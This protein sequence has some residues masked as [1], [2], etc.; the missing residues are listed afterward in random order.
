[1]S[2]QNDIEH[3][4]NRIE[5]GDITA[6]EANVELVRMHRVKV[7]KGRLP[8]DVRAALNAAVKDG[9]LDHMKKDG[10]KPEVYFHPEFVHMARSARSWSELRA[11][12]AIAK[13]AG[14]TIDEPRLVD[15]W[16]PSEKK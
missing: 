15:G 6:S 10:L 11:Q 1:M 9:R 3:L 16:V 12:N 4:Q 13:A 5:L 2:G 7:V 14:V 8:R